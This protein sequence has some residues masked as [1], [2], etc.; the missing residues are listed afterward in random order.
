MSAG[1]FE[2]MYESNSA[3]DVVEEIEVCVRH[4]GR[5][6]I[7]SKLDVTNYLQTR[8]GTHFEV[9]VWYTISF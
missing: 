1:T 4:P 5:E 3:Q 2:A 8:L 6:G 7:I 9:D